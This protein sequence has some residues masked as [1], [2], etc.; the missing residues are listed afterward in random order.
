MSL[1]TKMLGEMQYTFLIKKGGKKTCQYMRKRQELY[2]KIFKKTYMVL[3][4]DCFYSKIRN[5]KISQLLFNIVLEVL[6]NA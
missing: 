6:V 5:K 3:K 4:I 2:L 1:N